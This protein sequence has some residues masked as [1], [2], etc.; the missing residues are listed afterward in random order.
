MKIQLLH[1]KE[2][3]RIPSASSLSDGELAI[4]EV[5]KAIYYKALN[6][7]GKPEI[8]Q[9]YSSK[10]KYGETPGSLMLN[11]EEAQ[12]GPK[13]EDG[14]QDITGYTLNY[15]TGAGAVAIGVG[16]SAHTIGFCH[17]RK[18]SIEKNIDGSVAQTS[19]CFGQNNLLQGYASF[20]CGGNN[21]GLTWGSHVEGRY[22][23]A[24]NVQY[25]P[26]MIN[27]E[28]YD[29]YDPDFEGKRM[30]VIPFSWSESGDTKTVDIYYNASKP[31]ASGYVETLTEYGYCEEGELTVTTSWPPLHSKIE[32]TSTGV[33]NN[34][35]VQSR[36]KLIPPTFITTGYTVASSTTYTHVLVPDQ[37]VVYKNDWF[38]SQDGH[39]AHVEGESCIAT[40][41]ASHA[42]GNK[43]SA[44]NFCTH[45]EGYQTKALR[46]SAHAE[47]SE[48]TADGFAAHAEG[49]STIAS[50][51]Y[52][53]AEGFS[54]IAEGEGSHA[55]GYFTKAKNHSEFAC[56]RGNLSTEDE[57]DSNFGSANAGSNRTLFS[58]GNGHVLWNGEAY[59]IKAEHNALEVKQNGDI[60]ISDPNSTEGFGY[61]KGMVLLQD[62]LKTYKLTFKNNNPFSESE[63]K[64]C[65]SPLRENEYLCKNI[66]LDANG[67][68]ASPI[69]F[70]REIE[71]PT[72]QQPNPG[73]VTTQSLD[74]STPDDAEPRDS[75]QGVQGNVSF[76]GQIVKATLTYLAGTTLYKVN[77]GWDFFTNKVLEGWN[78]YTMT[79]LI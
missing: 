58:V 61:A 27:I 12:L 9:I 68:L 57:S 15:A 72:P 29:I 49:R 7:E 26:E 30:V 10:L 64:E 20:A 63:I 55:S 54:T 50:G 32:F 16:C 47:G 17:G 79:P 25:T 2:K 44:L 19:A 62:C 33:T 71:S 75:N 23:L 43:T 51:N 4:N 3:G 60:Y 31:N 35:V 11:H 14:K 37:G 39:C 42:Q 56:G 41:Y 76:K 77:I 48:S 78:N 28:K 21:S 66:V 13:K 46:R 59:E 40:G 36:F 73:D 18:N 34:G 8:N 1:S 45:A 5:D 69:S 67:T 74:L 65:L 52:S 24:K 6:D 53:H 38:S 70:K 22:S